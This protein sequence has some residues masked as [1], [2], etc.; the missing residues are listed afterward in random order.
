M[1]TNF[2]KGKS[3]DSYVYDAFVS[4]SSDDE[5]W[6]HSYLVTNLEKKAEEDD[7]DDALQ[8]CKKPKQQETPPK[9]K[10]ECRAVVL[11]LFEFAAH[12]S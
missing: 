4:Y 2:Q 11:N 7:N 9:K 1:L 10:K 6:V 12:Q 3:T 5:E 8:L